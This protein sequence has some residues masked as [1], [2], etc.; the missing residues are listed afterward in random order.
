MNNHKSLVGGIT[1]LILGIVLGVTW[2]NGDPDSLSSQR[3]IMAS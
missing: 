2:R 3:A 1:L